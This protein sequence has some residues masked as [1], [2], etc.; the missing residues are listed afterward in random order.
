MPKLE[1][2][3]LTLHTYLKMKGKVNGREALILHDDGS[4]HDFISERFAESLGL[5]LLRL[6]LRIK[7]II[8][9]RKYI[10]LTYLLGHM[11]KHV[12]F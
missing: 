8:A 12:L 1:A 4:T 6:L 11:S 9:L 7:S 5:E 10:M 2:H 3:I